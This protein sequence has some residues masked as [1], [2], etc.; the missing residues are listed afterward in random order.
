M[1]SEFSLDHDFFSARTLNDDANS[2]AHDF[3]T[4]SWLDAG[5]L[6]LPR[7]G[8]SDVLKL[9]DTFPPKFRQRWLEAI[10]YGKKYEVDR[11]WWDFSDYTDF[12]KLCELSSIFKTAFSEETAG[13][14][15]G[16]EDSY[17]Q[18]CTET[19]FELLAA[20]VCSESINITKSLGLSE[21]EILESDTPK[22]VWD[23]RF[24]A[25]ARHS[26]KITIVDRY[27]FENIRKA[28]S[29]DSTD[30]AMK[31]FFSFL[32]KIDKKFNIRIISHGGEKDSD[33]HN[34][35]YDAF[36]KGV[37]KV[38]I[39]WKAI[40]SLTLVSAKEEFFVKKSHD[41]FL[42]FDQHICQVGNGMRVLGSV[43]IP[44]STFLA[45]FDREGHLSRRESLASS[46][47]YK[48]WHENF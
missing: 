27:F 41:R 8:I 20:G 48:L 42:G 11:E 14:Q 33:F 22:Q 45:K 25:L 3:I 35:V 34:G 17:K 44:S 32:S 1:I 21:S 15:L 23:A 12:S 2:A 47:D 10:E 39:Y 18:F 28:A 29:R 19:S 5:V 36:Y 24:E 6:I 40:G 37:Y 9:I 16:V 46:R 7:G 13:L 38:P 31:N 26:K 4:R 30:E 43:P